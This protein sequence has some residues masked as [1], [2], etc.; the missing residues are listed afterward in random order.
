M[1]LG[2]EGTPKFGVILY[3]IKGNKFGAGEM[4]RWTQGEINCSRF[5]NRHLSAV[6]QNSQKLSKEI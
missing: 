4:E 2:E 3:V 5:F 6:G 1:E